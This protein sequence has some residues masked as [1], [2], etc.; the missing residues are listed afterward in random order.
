[1]NYSDDEAPLGEILDSIRLQFKSVIP[2]DYTWN[3]SMAIQ[4]A[5][6]A[7]H[8]A[9]LSL[10]SIEDSLAMLKKTKEILQQIKEAEEFLGIDSVDALM[11]D[12]L[13]ADINNLKTE[14]K[15]ALK[16]FISTISNRR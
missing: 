5:I 14:H 9:D 8:V 13:I 11:F 1:M 15:F 10:K 3:K 12:D 6:I 2:D 4:S 7:K 16:K